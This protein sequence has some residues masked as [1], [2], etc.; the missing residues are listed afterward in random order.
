MV[1]EMK[2]KVPMIAFSVLATVAFI[3]SINLKIEKEAVKASVKSNTSKNK[4]SY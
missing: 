1:A 3:L 2:G 4:S